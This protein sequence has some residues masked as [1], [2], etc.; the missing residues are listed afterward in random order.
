[1][2]FKTELFLLSCGL[3]RTILNIKWPMNNMFWCAFSFSNIFV[4]QFLFCCGRTFSLT[5]KQLY[6]SWA[7]IIMLDYT[8]PNECKLYFYRKLW[9]G[10]PMSTRGPATSRL[11]SPRD[12]N[13]WTSYKTRIITRTNWHGIH[14]LLS[15]VST[16][17]LTLPSNSKIWVI[18]DYN[19]VVN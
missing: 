4:T 7:T 15:I 13:Q 18:P 8:T 17:P 1:M 9:G 19:I 16:N 5:W 10:G 6:F 3:H 11:R 2:C 14:C 12:D